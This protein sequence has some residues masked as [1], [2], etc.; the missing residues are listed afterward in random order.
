VHGPGQR[1]GQTVR[2]PALPA[3]PHP[4]AGVRSVGGGMGAVEYGD[5]GARVEI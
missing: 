2:G 4:S 5:G 3:L 1:R